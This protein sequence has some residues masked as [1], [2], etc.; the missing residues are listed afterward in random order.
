MFLYY[1]LLRIILLACIQP[2]GDFVVM[3]EN[4]FVCAFWIAFLFGFIN[5]SFMKNPTL[6]KLDT[7]IFHENLY[8]VTRSKFTYQSHLKSVVNIQYTLFGFLSFSLMQNSTVTKLDTRI[9]HDI[10]HMIRKS[11]VTY[12]SQN[13]SE[14]SC[15][16]LLYTFW[17][18]HFHIHLFKWH[19]KR[20]IICINQQNST[21]TNLI[22]R[23]NMG[24]FICSQNQTSRDQKF[25]L[26]YTFWISQS[27]FLAH[28]ISNGNQ[29]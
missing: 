18:S 3:S 6:T 4:V 2:K 26:I 17:I 11:K 5:F 28:S 27:Q 22:Q 10:L 15:K 8:M 13:S 24:T 1:I 7:K 29:T 23:Y 20:T 21:M 14:I 19:V 25:D 12:H 16:P 9:Q